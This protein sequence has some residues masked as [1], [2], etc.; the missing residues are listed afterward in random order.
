[1]E[2]EFEAT[3][4]APYYHE[5]IR[6]ENNIFENCADVVFSGHHAKGLTFINNRDENGNLLTE[7]AVRLTDCADIVIG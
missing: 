1:M 5:N 6:V 7:K 3:E 4:Q 2:P